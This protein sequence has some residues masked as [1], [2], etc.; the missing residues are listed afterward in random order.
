MNY[1]VT[2]A[3][4]PT[5]DLVSKI[6][7]IL[8]G[9]TT[10]EADTIQADLSSIIS[11]SKPPK[12]NITRKRSTSLKSLQQNQNIILLAHRGRATVVLDKED[13]TKKCNEHLTSGPYTKLKKDPTSSIVSKVTKKLIELI[14]DNNLIEQQ[15]YFKLKPTGAQPPRF[16]GIPKVH[17]DGI[18]LAATN[19]IIHRNATV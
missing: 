18:P 7:T 1:S 15:E 3:A 9:R 17:K 11:K 19:R 13:Y 4:L 6:E 14:R 12:R 5:I 8:T 16:Y 2:P 10:E